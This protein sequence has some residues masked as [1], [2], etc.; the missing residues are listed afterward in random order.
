[1]D[2]M[3]MLVSMLAASLKRNGPM[4]VTDE[5]LWSWD[6]LGESIEVTRDEAGL[7]FHV[8]VLPPIIEGEVVGD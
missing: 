3:Q 1:M 2:Q 8:R 7:Q 4:T 6:A 5:E